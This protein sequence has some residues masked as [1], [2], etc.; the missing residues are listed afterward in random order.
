[1]VSERMSF[2]YRRGGVTNH[3]TLPDMKSALKTFAVNYCGP[4]FSGRLNFC[5]ES[6]ESEHVK[7]TVTPKASGEFVINMDLAFPHVFDREG[8]RIYSREVRTAA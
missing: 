4:C 5:L 7:I 8:Q 1:M 6:Y 2:D 3:D